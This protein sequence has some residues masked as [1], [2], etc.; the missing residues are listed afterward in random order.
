MLAARVVL[1]SVRALVVRPRLWSTAAVE[2]ARFAP[3]GWWRR[4]PFLPLPPAGLAGFRAETMY[5]DPAAE[6]SRSD[7][8][9][10][11]EWCRAQNPRPRVPRIPATRPR[12]R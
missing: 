3:N 9:V 6:P 5:G 2:F 4:P 1:K 11:L 8:I 10:W 12:H 7:V